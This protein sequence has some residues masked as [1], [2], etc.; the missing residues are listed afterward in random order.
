[1]T[2]TR[3]TDEQIT[4]AEIE[5][6]CEI[7]VDVLDFLKKQQERFVHEA[8]MRRIEHAMQRKTKVKP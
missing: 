5:L 1:M 6:A 3:I 2:G 8:I 4:E 7:A